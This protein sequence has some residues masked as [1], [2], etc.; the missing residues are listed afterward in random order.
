[1]ARGGMYDQLAGGF[2]RYSV[3]AAWVV[4]HF[5]K[6][7]YDNALLLR[8]YLHWW[9]IYGD[10]LAERVVRETVGFLLR[11]LRTPQGG[12]ASS[13][14]ADAA[15][16]KDRRTSGPGRSW[17]RCSAPTTPVGGRL[18]A[19]TPEGTF[20]EGASTLQLPGDPIDLDALGP[21]AH[22]AARG[23]AH[24]V[25]P[26]RDDKVVASWNGWTICALAEAGAL[27]AGAGLGGRGRE[28]RSAATRSTPTGGRLRRVSR[29][30]TVGCR[31]RG[32]GGLRRRRRWLDL[33]VR[34]HWRG[35][36]GSSRRGSLLDVALRRFP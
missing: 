27:L 4:P 7:L 15:G 30:G 20:E 35:R 16:S 29:D 12:F 21:A 22:G 3:D 32:A 33:P 24:R 14:D 23:R 19:V 6:M 36:A 11:D 34:G 8:A 5:E 13:L 9:R 25:Q 18:C 28:G 17:Q 10:P 1:M 26:R 2:A 31:G